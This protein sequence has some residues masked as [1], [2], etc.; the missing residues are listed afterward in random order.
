MMSEPVETSY[1]KDRKQREKALLARLNKLP[2]DNPIA[3]MAVKHQRADI[4]Q[5]Q[6]WQQFQIVDELVSA[7]R[8]C[9]ADGDDFDEAVV[10]LADALNSLV[11]TKSKKTD[12]DDSDE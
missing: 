6:S 9:V 8:K 1:E 12:D 3:K 2:K 5:E 4:N 7:A 11:G 10:N